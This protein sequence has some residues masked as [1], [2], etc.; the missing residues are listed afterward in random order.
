MLIGLV[1]TQP[2]QSLELKDLRPALK[3]RYT[4]QLEHAL[5]DARFEQ[6]GT[7]ARHLGPES[8]PNQEELAKAWSV[9]QPAVSYALKDLIR[10]GCVL[11]LARRGADPATYTFSGLSRLA[12]A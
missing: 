4:D 6:L 7:W 11:Q 1:G 9:S 2:N 12:L 10:D 5:S 8:T 3:K